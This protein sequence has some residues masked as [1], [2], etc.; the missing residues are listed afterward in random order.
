MLFIVVKVNIFEK[1]QM[2]NN[3]ENNS[4]SLGT[5][6]NT[7]LLQRHSRLCG[8]CVTPKISKYMAP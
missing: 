7:G 4:A 1:M 3:L 2:L 5:D 6:A 8:Q